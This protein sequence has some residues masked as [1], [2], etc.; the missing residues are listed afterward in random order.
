[1]EDRMS[2][3]RSSHPGPEGPHAL[4]GVSLH[5]GTAVDSVLAESVFSDAREVT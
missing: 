2:R 3:A 5:R 1:M 4:T